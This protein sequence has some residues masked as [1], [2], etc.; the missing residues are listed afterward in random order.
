[1]ERR[2]LSGT[3]DLESSN[4]SDVGFSMGSVALDHG[5]GKLFCFQEIEEATNGFS[6][7]NVIDSGD[8]WVVYQ[9]MLLDNNQVAVK[10]LVFERYPFDYFCKDPTFHPISSGS[11][12]RAVEGVGHVEK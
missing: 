9:G 4:D 7:E 5:W 3:T 2:L 12:Y 11:G 8:Y 10:D 6:V 1:M